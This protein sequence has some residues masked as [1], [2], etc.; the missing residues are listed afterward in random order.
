VNVCQQKNCFFVK[1]FKKVYGRAGIGVPSAL[2]QR[3][4]YMG[5]KGST[6]FPSV[7]DNMCTSI[8]KCST[9]NGLGG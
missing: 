5:S 6:P 7:V 9:E 3:P 2:L 4:T 8:H 1:I